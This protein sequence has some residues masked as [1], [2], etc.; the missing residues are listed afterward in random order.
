LVVEKEKSLN[1]TKRSKKKKRN[2]QFVI[3]VAN[4]VYP[5]VNYDNDSS[6]LSHEIDCS[7][8][9]WVKLG[10]FLV[11]HGRIFK[12]FMIITFYFIGPGWLIELVLALI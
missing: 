9:I 4:L 6:N 8:K 10:V 5:L 12:L 3:N 7:W 2:G 1:I 11:T